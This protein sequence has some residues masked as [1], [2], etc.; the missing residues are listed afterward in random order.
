MAA[1]RKPAKVEN[2]SLFSESPTSFS[3]TPGIIDEA[4]GISE[5]K[6]QPGKLWVQQDSGNPPELYL[7][8]HD[9]VVNRSVYIKGAINRDWEDIIIAPGPLNNVNYI[10]LADVGDN[11]QQFE[12]YRLYR[13][14][15]PGS[16]IDTVSSWEKISFRYPDGSHDAEA[17]LADLH[18][19]DI[20]I[21]TKQDQESGIYKLQYPQA[22]TGEQTAVFVG[23]LP[24]NGVVS[25]CISKNNKE[26]LVK[27][28]LNVYYW[29]RDEQMSIEDILKNKPV[30]ISY[31]PE[32][33]GEAIC[34][35][36][37]NSG[38]FTLSEKGLAIAVALNF[39]RRN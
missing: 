13:F 14:P 11:N 25:A 34:F 31:K 16:G 7:L 5:S 3:I 35:K 22:T 33:Q 19:K 18:S 27:T 17:I 10:Y 6:T 4:S 36:N 26:I 24:F 1:C 37:D 32:S 15:E 12:S 23:S 38:F 2:T 9:G 20:Y 30:T 28:Y 39:Y 8:G 21:I 29:K